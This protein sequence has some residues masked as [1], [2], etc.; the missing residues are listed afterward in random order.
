MCTAPVSPQK[1]TATPKTGS[2]PARA[3][4]ATT[5]CS[6]KVP[7]LWYHD[8]AMGL[9]RLN[10][11]AGLFG[12]MLVRDKVRGRTEP[13]HRQV[14]SPAHPLRP[15]TS[16]PMASSLLSR[17]RRPRAPLDLRV[18]PAMA[19]L[20]N[21]KIRPYFEVEPR[22]YRFRM[23]NAANS[24]FFR[25]SLSNKQTLHQVGGDQGLLPASVEH[26]AATFAPGERL[27]LLVDF[28]NAAGQTIHLRNGA[29]DILQFRVGASPA[30]PSSG[31]IPKSIRTIERLPESSA[32]TTRTITLNEYQ[33]GVGN[34]MEMLLNRKRW[35]EPVTERPKPQH[36]R[37]SGSSSTSPK[38]STR[39]TCIWSASKSSTAAS[40]TRSPT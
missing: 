1:T 5:R 21:G 16:Q 29:F 15:R 39:C 13:A 33:D 24:R 36:H 3:S 38:T 30:Q 26:S 32:I 8:H 6:R 14:R 35:H 12:M 22:L 18:Q 17:L 11:Y 25:L 2:F 34:S 19:I 31:S 27:D 28:S 9:N 20:I 40:S 4:P 10:V 23:V 37:R 7:T